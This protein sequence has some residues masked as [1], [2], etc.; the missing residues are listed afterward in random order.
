M[1]VLTRKE[2]ESITIFPAA[3]IGPATTIGELFRNPIN[4][5]INE[6]GHYVQIGIAVPS[7]VTVLRDELAG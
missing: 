4:I 6:A 3:E 1:L 5:T 2:G 7:G